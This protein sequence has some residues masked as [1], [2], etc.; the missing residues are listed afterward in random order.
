MP[1]ESAIAQ[2]LATR[3]GRQ[4]R[5]GVTATVTVCRFVV[6]TE[7]SLSLVHERTE[8]STKRKRTMS[9]AVIL[10][11]SYMTL[12]LHVASVPSC[13]RLP[14]AFVLIGEILG[15]SKIII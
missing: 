3:N 5:V 2:S 14:I 4:S 11:V 1:M 12:C 13:A 9:R 7:G 10:Y 6:V 8:R 15:L